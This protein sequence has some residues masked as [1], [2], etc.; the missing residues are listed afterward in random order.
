MISFPQV[1]P[2]KPCISLLL[3]PIRATCPAHL[4]LLDFI[5]RTILGE[6]YTSLSSSLCSFLHSHVYE[7]MWKDIVDPGRAQMTI[8]RMR[9]ACWIPKATN[10][11][12]EYVILVTFLL[13]QWLYER[14]S[15]LRNT[16]YIACVVGCDSNLYLRYFCYYL[17]VQPTVVRFKRI[18]WVVII[19]LSLSY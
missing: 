5:N 19:L 6:K 9:I 3:F 7:I 14:T 17:S 8:W 2:P 16:Y 1:S 18:I 12:S 4:I 13:Q 15:I 11:H 10:A